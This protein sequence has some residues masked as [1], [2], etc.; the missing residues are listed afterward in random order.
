M[1]K[2]PPSNAGDMSSILG[3][4]TK[5]PHST[6]Q[7]NLYHNNRNPYTVMKI[8]HAATKTQSSQ[9]N[10]LIKKK[11]KEHRLE[12][13]A[14]QYIQNRLTEM[15]VP[16]EPVCVF[17]PALPWACLSKAESGWGKGGEVVSAV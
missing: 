9:I 1:V 3:W 8:L 2:N 7:L 15:V 4:G 6:G 13:P 17:L 10:E 11:K 14:L 5:T 12:L 16:R